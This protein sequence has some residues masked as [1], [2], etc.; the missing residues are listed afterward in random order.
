MSVPSTVR[1]IARRFAILR[2]QHPFLGDVIILK[3]TVEG[4]KFTRRVIQRHFDQL[5]GK[6]EYA[7]EDRMEIIEYLLGV[8]NS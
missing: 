4:Q 8:S 1:S 5:V 6:K 2:D 7:E 3:K